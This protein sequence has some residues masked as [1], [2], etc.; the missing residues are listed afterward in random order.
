MRKGN[1]KVRRYNKS[2]KSILEGNALR[3]R[4]G[5]IREMVGNGGGHIGGSLDLA[6]MLSVIYTD[7]IRVDINN[8]SWEDRDYMILSK[9]HAGPALYSALAFK[10]FFPENRL[11]SLNKPDVFLP[12]H[13]DRR[14]PGVDATTGSL[15][16]GLSIACGAALAAKIK[17][18]EQ[19]IF[20]I[21]G[22]GESDEGQI[23]EAAQAA[24][25]YKLDNLIAFL[26]WNK[27]QIDGSNDEVMSLGDP[28]IKFAAFDWNAVKVK[29]N[30]VTEISDAVANAL[31]KPNGK[32]TMIILD[33]LKG[34]GIIGV[35]S[36]KNNHCIGFPEPLRSESIAELQKKAK[37]L[38][39]ELDES[40][41]E[42]K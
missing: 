32:P 11:D 15:G 9:G 20:C 10:G 16:Q 34:E 2:E 22:D 23:W 31:E 21:I 6:D 33:T 26:D 25:H 37:E 38:G 41:I 36:M 18:S 39:I 13:A 4:W 3:I 24:A 35:S 30:C 28:Q 19:V 14:V 8:P 7:C 29:G 17:R 1:R 42:K 5:I 40:W 27:M 12:G